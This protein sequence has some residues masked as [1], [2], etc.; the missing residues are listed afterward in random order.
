MT[1]EN[2]PFE[3]F[4]NSI[5]EFH[6]SIENFNFNFSEEYL[7]HIRA[8]L[9]KFSNLN[10]DD[11][12]KNLPKTRKSLP[13]TAVRNLKTAYTEGNLN[14][15]LGAGISKTFGIPTW[16]NLLQRLLLK[17]IEQ[18]TDKATVLS[19]IFTKTFNPSPLIAGRYLQESLKDSKNK[20]KFEKEVRNALYE[21]LDIRAESSIMDEIIRLCTPN[22]NSPKLDGI[23]TYNYDDIIESKL[24]KDTKNTFFQ[25]VYGQTI[26]QNNKALAIYHVHGYLP[27]KGSLSRKNEITLGELIY[28]EQYN[29]IYSWNNIVQINKFRDKTCLFIGSSLT[30]P[31]IRRLLDIANAQKEKRKYH[32]LL[33][34]S[35]SKKEVK[36]RV[37]KI[38]KDN[39]GIFNQKVKAKLGSDELVDF[40]IKMENRFVE[41]DTQSLGVKT[42]WIDDYEKDISY[43]LEKIRE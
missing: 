38:L 30:D 20:N 15:V 5:E 40:L 8:N 17:T 21:T 1:L 6:K 13:K 3:N 27:Q 10:Y 9:E 43:I 28:H 35:P 12:V 22:K 34:A 41:I 25:S 31:N 33:K 42:V 16:E 26:N 37:D 24:R 23:I 14:L 18:E 29:N 7:N 11:L 39:P 4:N 19:K 36:S 32:Y 2:N